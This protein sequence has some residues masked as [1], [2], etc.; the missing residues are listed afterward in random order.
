MGRLL[1]SNNSLLNCKMEFYE[2][3]F[4]HFLLILY[5]KLA[6]KNVWGLNHIIII[7]GEKG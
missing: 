7:M 3:H 2:M 4:V 1:A 6:S 5:Y